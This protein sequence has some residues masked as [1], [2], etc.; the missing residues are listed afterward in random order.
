MK[1]VLKKKV[2]R[3]F[4]GNL[5]RVEDI[6]INNEDEKE[7]VIYRALYDNKLWVRPLDSFISLVDKN[8]YPNVTQ[9][10]KFELY[11]EK[12]VKTN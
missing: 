5:Y 3:H 7:Y 4:K 12:S 8:K 6:A 1:E 9:I 11:E 2:Y 10:H